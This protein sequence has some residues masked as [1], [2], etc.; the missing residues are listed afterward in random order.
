MVESVFRWTVLTVVSGLLSA[1]SVTL[2]PSQVDLDVDTQ[3]HAPLPHQGSVSGLAQWWHQQGDPLLVELIEAAQLVSPTLAQALSRTESARAAQ[4]AA[5]SMLLPQVSASVSASRGV[6]QPNVPAAT[7]I[8]GG[9]QASW[10]LDLVGANRALSAAALAQLE[11]AQAQWHD[12]RVLVAAEVAH[13][14]YGLT[15]CY[16]LLA[17]ARQDAASRLQ[18][19]QT[20]A[21]GLKAGFTA[22]SV[23]ALANASAAEA[24]ARENQ[25][26]TACEAQVKAL[27]ALT[28]WPESALR[29]KMALAKSASMPMSGFVWSSVPAQTIAQRPDVFAAERDLVLASAQVGSAKAQRYPRLYLNGSIG[30]MRYSSMGVDTQ[31]N[32]WSMGPLAVSLPVFDGGQRAANVTLAQTRYAESV[33]L[34]RAKVRQAVREVEESLLNLQSNRV[35]MQEAKVAAQGYDQYLQATNVSY[36]QGF[37]SLTDLEEARRIAL[38]AQSALIATELDGKRSWISLYRALGGGFQP[39]KLQ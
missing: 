38:S 19:A 27:V 23:A 7:T 3:W 11:G 33:S 1:C 26:F 39:E 12:A 30:A 21:A 35:R 34:Y 36:Q 29:S 18:T 22:P 13:T 14:Y 24:R 28:A 10:E 2:P 6:S 37:A 32:T 5:G 16:Q 17:V 9:L 20:T 25:Q 31:L 8:Q 4:V 15:S